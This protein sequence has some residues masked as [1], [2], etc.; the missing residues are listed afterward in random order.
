LRRLR[1]KL[2]REL[3]RGARVIV[4][5]YPVEGWKPKEIH[6]AVSERE[7]VKIFLYEL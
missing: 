2:E 3:K 7:E 1:S 5:K 4:Y 6:D